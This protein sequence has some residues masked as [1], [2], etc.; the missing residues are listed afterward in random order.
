M[1]LKVIECCLQPFF[2]ECVMKNWQ[3]AHERVV[4][5]EWH[6]LRVVNTFTMQ[7]N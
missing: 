5:L 4:K 6:K 2:V 1:V 3:E 7:K